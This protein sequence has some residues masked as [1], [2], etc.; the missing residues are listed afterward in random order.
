MFTPVALILDETNH[1]SR[2]T[3]ILIS[4][5]IGTYFQRRGNWKTTGLPQN[6]WISIAKRLHAVE[7]L[8]HKTTI[9][10]VLRWKCCQ[11]DSDIS[12]FST[13]WLWYGARKDI[14]S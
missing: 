4:R 7:P 3:A 6:Q 10:V 5:Q 9:S 11:R 14:V 1:P 12:G 2:P 13:G 8:A